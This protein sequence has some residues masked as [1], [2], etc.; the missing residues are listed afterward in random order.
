MLKTWDLQ[1]DQYVKKSLKHDQE[2]KVHC[3]HY[4]KQNTQR[5]K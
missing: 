1:G 5:E 4:W 3:D 2:A